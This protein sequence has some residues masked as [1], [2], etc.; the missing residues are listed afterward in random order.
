MATQTDVVRLSVAAQALM[1]IETPQDAQ[2]TMKLADLARVYA[3]KM[4][5]G[6]EAENAATAIRLKAEIRLAE[7][8]T[9]GQAA[10]E[11]AKAGDNPIVR[12]SDNQVSTLADLGVSPQ[13]LSE[14]RTIAEAFTLPAID[15]LSEEASER[16]VS[17]SRASVLREAR[18]EA[19]DKF[20]RLADSLIDPETRDR[21]ALSKASASLL[22]ALDAIESI[23]RPLTESEAEPMLPTLSRLQQKLH[24][25]RSA[26]L[27]VVS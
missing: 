21:H 5:L 19:N 7:T 22:V 17:L 24:G 11:I 13:R 20:D 10:G 2:R 12:T 1:A 27:E 4:A 23:G 25:K 16:G 3:R 9:A 15:G 8:V 26:R 14:A 18:N 6:A